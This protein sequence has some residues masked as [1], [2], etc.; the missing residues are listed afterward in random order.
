M[1]IKLVAMP[2]TGVASGFINSAPNSITPHDGEQAGH[3]PSHA[4]RY[5]DG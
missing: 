4:E 3:N 2:M 1:R 5:V